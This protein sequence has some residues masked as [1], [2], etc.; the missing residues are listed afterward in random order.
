MVKQFRIKGLA[1]AAILAAGTIL[2]ACGSSSG[3]SNTEQTKATEA[4]E[5]V[6]SSENAEPLYLTD[7]HTE[8]IVI[9]EIKIG[10]N[11]DG[12]TFN[13]NASPQWS[14]I[15]PM[16]QIFERLLY[17]DQDTGEVYYNLASS[18]D[19]EEG[20]TEVIIHLYENIYDT[21][22]NHF[23]AHDFVFDLEELVASGKAGNLKK[24]K[25]CEAVDDYTIKWELT[26]PFVPGEAPAQLG[27][28]Q[29]YTRAAYEASGDNFARRPVGTS[30]YRLTNYTSG[31]SVTLE[32][33]GNY[34]Q[35]DESLVGITGKQNVKK[36]IY[37][38]I[39]EQS[40]LAIALQTGAIDFAGSISDADLINFEND[41]NYQI[42]PISQGA[43]Y[44]LTFNMS[45]NSL[46]EDMNLRF[47]IIYALNIDDI[48]AGITQKSNR[49]YGTLPTTLFD[50]LDEWK[51]KEPYYEFDAS[52]AKEYLGK[53]NYNGEAL[54][55]MCRTG[56]VNEGIALMIKAELEQLGIH[57]E[58]AAYDNAMFT[59]NQYDAD[60]YD[61]LLDLHG[62][63]RPNAS[64][65]WQNNVCDD[66]W[67][68]NGAVG[69]FFVK[70]DY[71]QELFDTVYMTNSVE[72]IKAMEKY[73]QENAMVY[74]LNQ[75]INSMVCREH[76][77]YV[78]NMSSHII[79]GACVYSG[80]WAK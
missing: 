1:M 8:S 3:A 6:E 25:T 66:V 58:I 53:T 61:M 63:S 72:D 47:A 40:Q 30:G 74:G 71:L 54:K 65:Y 67:V 34:W 37:N 35:K 73:L 57:V 4:A 52:K 14:K 2:S 31:S 45:D 24:L 80:G 33:T 19:Y 39:L 9:D 27:I 68:M 21:D 42:I 75:L 76:I 59:A 62:G 78:R 44:Q 38:I 32:A 48:V 50:A 18:Y 12:G 11:S 69:A 20:S 26:E 22:G 15:S 43:P 55:L 56:T 49:L 64:I 70:D 5:I 10:I 17:Q 7:I 46:C 23:T 60:G 13:P 77:R 36:I 51:N 28:V 29:C 41:A 79:P 16:S